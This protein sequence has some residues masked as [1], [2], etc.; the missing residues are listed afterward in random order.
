MNKRGHGVWWFVCVCVV[1]KGGG[2]HTELKHPLVNPLFRVY[3]LHSKRLFNYYECCFR[4]KFRFK[5]YKI[6]LIEQAMLFCLWGNQEIGF[7][8]NICK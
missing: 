4:L 5:S 8:R 1:G 6:R 3:I 7:P 2:A